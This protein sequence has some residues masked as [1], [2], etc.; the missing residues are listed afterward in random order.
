VI[1]QVVSKT[2]FCQ[3]CGS[4]YS[5]AVDG[6]RVDV[7]E[8]VLLKFCQN[9]SKVRMVKLSIMSKKILQ[10]LR[11]SQYAAEVLKSRCFSRVAFVDLE[12]FFFLR[13]A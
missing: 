3:R 11:G 9:T 6:W 1:L 2:C 7:S 5:L 8:S 4:S 13:E 12:S 10:E